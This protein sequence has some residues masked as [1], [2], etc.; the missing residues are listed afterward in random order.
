MIFIVLLLGLILRLISINQSLWLDEAIG[1]EVAKNFSYVKILTEFVKFDNHPPLYY[2][3]LKFWTGIFGYSELGLRSLSIVFGL[4]TIFLTVKI[5]EKLTPKIYKFVPILPALFLATSQIHIYY[6]QEAR[7]YSM[8][9]FL[10]SLAVY[11]FISS[12]NGS[13]R[14]NWFLFS[15]SI[16]ILMFTDYIPVFLLPIFWIYAFFKIRDAY[17]WRGFILS[18]FPL[19]ILGYF[20]LPTFLYQSERGRW[21]VATLSGW[22]NIAGG[23][24]IKQAL[25]VF[26]KF[27]FG[28]ISLQDK[29]IYYLLVTFASFPIILL[30]YS[31][32]RNRKKE[33]DI[34]WLWLTLPLI[35][36]FLT[37][38][39]FPAFTY[40][41]FIYVLPA[42]YILVAW[43]AANIKRKTLRNTTLALL[44]G[45]N[46]ISWLIY[47][48]D[49]NQQRENWR[50]A[51]LFIESNCKAEEIVLF[52]Y[53]EP[54]TP[55]R[56]YMKGSI[57]A[58]GATDSILANEI[59]SRE[60]TE[61]LIEGKNAA[62]LFDYLRELSDPSNIVGESL[63]RNGF[64]L[65]KK[66]NFAGV[67][68]VEY[69]AKQ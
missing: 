18:H 8:T 40:F 21:L 51:V 13:D 68:F 6:S 9:T 10:A 46:L 54:F 2:L 63:S 14:K 39:L 15:L 28:R 64:E 53:P 4:G 22:K 23:A 3:L 1:A 16:S 55:Y 17:W 42:F 12:L 57:E 45:I 29:I 67:G 38:F 20:W 59:A 26:T 19:V 62:Y 56:W 30:L 65:E 37:S 44:V 35:L 32:W 36:G 41:R 5:F 43:G 31:A 27:V 24:T 7:M 11:F 25:L 49:K 47:V 52:H 34:I 48:F 33:F 61:K 69:W 50:E 58:E 66:L 60:K